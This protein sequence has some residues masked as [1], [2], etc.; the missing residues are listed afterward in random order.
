MRCG[1]EQEV[2]MGRIIISENQN[3][4]IFYDIYGF[5]HINLIIIFIS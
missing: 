5:N 4:I 3:I 1:R 2:L